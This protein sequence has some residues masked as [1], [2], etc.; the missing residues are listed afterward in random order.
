MRQHLGVDLD[1]PR[2]AMVVRGRT[3]D[4]PA[5]TRTAPARTMA[6]APTVPAPPPSPGPAPVDVWEEVVPPTGTRRYPGPVMVL[7]AHGIRLSAKALAAIGFGARTT[8][9]VR[10]VLS[11]PT[12]AVRISRDPKGMWQAG[13]LR[14]QGSCKFVGDWLR[15]HGVADGAHPLAVL[16][17]D[18]RKVLEFRVP[19]HD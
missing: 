2:V 17:E 10:V 12:G 1:A 7:S 11:A 16:D 19:R 4:R 18:G 3:A 13:S 8:G 6:A 5:A 9:P 14:T 15:G